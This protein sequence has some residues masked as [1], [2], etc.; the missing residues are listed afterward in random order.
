MFKLDYF[1]FSKSCFYLKFLHRT[2]LIQ[3]YLIVYFSINHSIAKNCILWNSHFTSPWISFILLSNISTSILRLVNYESM[4]IK[5]DLIIVL[6]VSLS[7]IQK[8]QNFENFVQRLSCLDCDCTIKQS[9]AN[10][11]H[12]KSVN[13]G[14]NDR[15][16][17]SWKGLSAIVS[18][19]SS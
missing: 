8:S 5:N 10:T 7:F 13:N 1:W 4:K 17:C 9:L 12:I 15:N 3:T 2:I 19:P 14:C 16:L 18:S 6:I 11:G